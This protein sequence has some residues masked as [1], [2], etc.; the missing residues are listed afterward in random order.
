M[1]HVVFQSN[2]IDVLNQ[3]IELDP[4]LRGEVVQI[5]DDFAVGPIKD[6][7]SAGGIQTRKNWWREVLAGGDYHGAVDD[8]SV[9]DDNKTVAT[10]AEK[11]AGDP[12]ERI[13]I[14]VAQNKHDVSSYYWLI[15]QLKNFQSRIFVL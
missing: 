14:W 4:A 2:D 6:I 13:W 9:A 10:L 11:L 5:A 1:I 7:F 15:S 3:A 12:E 8:G